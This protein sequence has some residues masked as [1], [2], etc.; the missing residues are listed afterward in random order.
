MCPVTIP[1]KLTADESKFRYQSLLESSVKL[2][3][4]T[5]QALDAKIMI[6]TRKLLAAAP[7]VRRQVK[8]LTHWG[9][10][11]FYPVGTC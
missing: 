11:A 9:Q 5:D 3:D 2:N 6:T 8:D 7:E 4:L 1:P 10:G